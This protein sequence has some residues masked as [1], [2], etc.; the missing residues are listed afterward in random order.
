MSPHS[1]TA[2]RIT[3]PNICSA[4]F[5]LRYAGVFLAAAEAK[6]KRGGKAKKAEEDD[7]DALL[8]ELDGPKAPEP[9][10]DAASGK[11]KKKKGKGAAAAKEE[12]DLDALLAEFGA[13][14]PAKPATDAAGASAGAVTAEG[15][16]EDANEPEDADDDDDGEVD[17]KV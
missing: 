11:K 5:T 7:I 2:T 16:P 10:A 12:E 14:V 6:S 1:T 13:P 9:V 15:P 3:I 4:L 17:E 8:A